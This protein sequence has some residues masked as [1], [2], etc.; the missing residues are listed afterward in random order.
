[1]PEAAV[2]VELLAE[3]VVGRFDEWERRPLGGGFF[4]SGPAGAVAGTEGADGLLLLFLWLGLW[5][6][7]RLLLQ[8]LLPSRTSTG[9][10]G[11]HSG[12]RRSHSAMLIFFVAHVHDGHIRV[13]RWRHCQSHVFV[14][15]HN[16]L[17]T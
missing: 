17:H 12:R 10:S 7:L 1:M 11:L 2:L 9:T 5:L 3:R 13:N 8:S 15:S 4:G 6:L 14:Y 16:P